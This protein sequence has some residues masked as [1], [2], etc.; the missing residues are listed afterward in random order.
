MDSEESGISGISGVVY[1]LISS[2]ISRPR[3]LVVLFISKLSCFYLLIM[4][5]LSLVL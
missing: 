3:Y 5:M 2:R 1:G 4:N